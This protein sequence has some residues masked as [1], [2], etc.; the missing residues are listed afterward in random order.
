LGRYT[1]RVAIS[2]HRLLS[3][4]RG[5]ITFTYRDRRDGDRRKTMILPADQFIGRFLKHTLPDRFM[6][7][8]H[9]GLLANRAKKERLAIC[10]HLL[11]V[12]PP[13][14][15][16]PKTP[17]DWLLLWTGEDV[18]RCPHCGFTPLTIEEI[19]RPRWGV[20]PTPNPDDFW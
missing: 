13:E 14:P 19:P 5:Q 4:E 15:S 12:A 6:R 1:H 3:I 16:E 7:I 8:R 2:N 20:W 10:R 18:T 9:Y 11:G 17:A